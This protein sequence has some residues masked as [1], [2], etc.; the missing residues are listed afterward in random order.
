MN[1]SVGRTMKGLFPVQNA[2]PTLNSDCLS[3]LI[4]T[5]G[6]E[7][8]NH[9]TRRMVQGLRPDDNARSNR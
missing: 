5:S 1:W 4:N 3:K 6:L 7:P 2:P 8:L 9:H